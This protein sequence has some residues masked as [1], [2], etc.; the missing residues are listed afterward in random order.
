MSR[1]KVK[2]KEKKIGQSV[3]INGTLRKTQYYTCAAGCICI[4]HAYL[5]LFCSVVTVI[6]V[7]TNTAMCAKVCVDS[8]ECGHR[9]N[10]VGLSVY[11]MVRAT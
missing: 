10:I 2:K 6:T 8:L 4:F 3:S 1:V 9:K 11:K 5:L 7:H